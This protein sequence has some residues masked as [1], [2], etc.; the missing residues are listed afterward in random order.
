MKKI[1]SE[2]PDMLILDIYMPGYSGLEVCE[3]V[4]GAVETANTP[5][6]LT[7]APMEPYSAVDDLA[8]LMD[9]LGL[10]TAHLVGLSNG[11][12]IAL[13][14]ALVHPARIRSLVLASLLPGAAAYLRD[15]LTARRRA[16][17]NS[18]N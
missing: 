4:K 13:D 6:L 18:A 15:M 8:A 7:V 14:F 16:R 5:V 12:R 11:A 17:K 2:R 3:K 10:A 9:E 1:A